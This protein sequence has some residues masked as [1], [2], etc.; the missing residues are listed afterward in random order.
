MTVDI[1]KL[2]KDIIEA[3]K[4]AGKGNNLPETHCQWYLPARTQRVSEMQRG[5]GLSG[6]YGYEGLRFRHGKLQKVG[7]SC[8]DCSLGHYNR[9][10]DRNTVIYGD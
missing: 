8:Y 1:E 2:K 10:C 7:P 6:T 9:D 5:A 3:E 4:I